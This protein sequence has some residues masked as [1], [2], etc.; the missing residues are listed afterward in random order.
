LIDEQ[1]DGTVMEADRL[2]P[3]PEPDTLL[4]ACAQLGVEPEQAATFETT[5]AGVEAGRDAH[6]GLVIAID[7]RGGADTFRAHGAELVVPDLTAL[8][9]RRM[10]A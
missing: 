6:L 4:A 9:D 7:R 10:T 5:L 2:R 1:I 3:K 8:L